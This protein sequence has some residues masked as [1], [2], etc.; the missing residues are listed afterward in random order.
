M[1][2]LYFP[3]T[4]FSTS[5]HISQR[6]PPAYSLSLRMVK[7]RATRTKHHDL[8][9]QVCGAR[10][11]SVEELLDHMRESGC[12]EVTPEKTAS[13]SVDLSSQTVSSKRQ[14]P[15]ES[16]LTPPHPPLKQV[17]INITLA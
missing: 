5:L 16:R 2:L 1:S 14:S 3:S 12:E 17:S 6:P 11:G 7:S 10:K 9:C 13:V 15:E 4:W 8:V